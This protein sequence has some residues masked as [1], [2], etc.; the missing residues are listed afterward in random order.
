MRAI[1]PIAKRHLAE[2]AQ[3]VLGTIGIAFLLVGGALMFAAL[4][5][6]PTEGWD[7]R[8]STVPLAGDR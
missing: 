6:N 8:D 1:W 4:L 3:M 7:E 2:A 5:L